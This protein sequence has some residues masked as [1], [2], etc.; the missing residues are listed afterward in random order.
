MKSESHRQRREAVPKP[1][2]AK[3][4]ALVISP[5]Q[6]LLYEVTKGASERLEASVAHDRQSL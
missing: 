2:R 6:N 1:A 4:L 5:N 3:R